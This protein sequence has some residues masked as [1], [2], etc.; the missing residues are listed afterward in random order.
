MIQIRL[1]YGRE[2]FTLRFRP[3]QAVLGRPVVSIVGCECIPNDHLGHWQGLCLL[4]AVGVESRRRRQRFL[5]AVALAQLGAG[6]LI[7][8][9]LTGINLLSV[10]EFIQIPDFLTV[11]ILSEIS[12]LGLVPVLQL[13]AKIIHWAI[14]FRLCFALGCFQNQRQLLQLTVLHLLL[15]AKIGRPFS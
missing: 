5:L 1:I 9:V 13:F 7:N 11:S 12:S 14:E 6:V 3:P 10:V 4:A 15:L 8:F 2:V